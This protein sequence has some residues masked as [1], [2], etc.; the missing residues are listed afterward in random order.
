MIAGGDFNLSH[1][2]SAGRR[3]LEEFAVAH[4]LRD[5]RPDARGD[6]GVGQVDYIL[7]RSGDGVTLD[8]LEAGEAPEFAADS[9]PLSDHPA[10]HARF[11][12]R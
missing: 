12:V 4:G 11:R 7:Y 10:I 1:C 9:H 8:L 2:D 3:L 6:C 5:S